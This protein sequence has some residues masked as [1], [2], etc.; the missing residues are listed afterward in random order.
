MPIDNINDI[1]RENNSRRA[2]TRSSIGVHLKLSR[3]IKHY[4]YTLQFRKNILHTNIL[5]KR[6]SDFM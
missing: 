4:I 5:H 6:R 2:D 3:E 1:S